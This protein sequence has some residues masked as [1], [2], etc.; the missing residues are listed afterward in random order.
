MKS[1]LDNP[2]FSNGDPSSDIIEHELADYR[3]KCLDIMNYILQFPPPDE[4]ASPDS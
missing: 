1:L 2:I 3:D 4:A